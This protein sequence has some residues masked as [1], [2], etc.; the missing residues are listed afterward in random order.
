VGHPAASAA[1]PSL[2]VSETDDGDAPADAPNPPLDPEQAERDLAERPILTSA[3]FDDS[4]LDAMHVHAM[5]LI[6]RAH[7]T[8]DPALERRLRAMFQELASMPVADPGH[9]RKP[10]RGAPAAGQMLALADTRP[11]S[12]VPVRDDVDSVEAGRLR[13]QRTLQAT[14]PQEATSS[15]APAASTGAGP[16]ATTPVQLPSAGTAAP[17]GSSAA[18][19]TSGDAARRDDGL[20]F[21][22]R[23]NQRLS[24]AL[25]HFLET[26]GWRLEWES[27]SD[28][29]VRRG[30]VVKAPTLRQVLLQT[31]GE[32][33]LS[34]V[35][36]S[37]NLVVAVS[38]GDR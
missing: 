38:G 4:Q 36:Y 3:L 19:A 23:D 32:Y 30:Y 11:R 37:G 9:K 21:E 24:Q 18:A 33:R 31:L 12:D 25:G 35:L 28:F 26:L 8:G 2:A 16:V 17:A 13:T 14:S 1:R 7:E 29:V 20:V 27:Q 6:A 5:E 34:A 22:V 15:V 10:G